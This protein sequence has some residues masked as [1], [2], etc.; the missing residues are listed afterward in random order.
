MYFDFKNN[1][2]ISGS[3]IRALLGHIPSN[4]RLADLQ[5]Y[6]YERDESKSDLELYSQGPVVLSGSSEGEYKA[7]QT[8]TA[9]I[10]NL[11]NFQEQVTNVF[12]IMRAALLDTTSTVELSSRLTS[13][14]KKVP[15]LNPVSF[16]GYYPLY[17]TEDRAESKSD[18]GQATSVVLQ[19]ITFYMPACGVTLYKGDY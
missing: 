17:S 1:T 15:D 12:T 14:L 2:P 5:I 18:N 7:V 3:T 6:P 16:D 4:N 19:G 9:Q 8:Y 11:N 10:D 13:A